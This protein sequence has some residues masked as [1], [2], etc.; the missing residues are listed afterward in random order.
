MDVWL[1]C[2]QNLVSTDSLAKKMPADFPITL[3]Y[4]KLSVELLFL[5]IFR[6]FY[7][8]LAFS[9]VTARDLMDYFWF[10]RN[11]FF[12]NANYVELMWCG[13][14]TLI[15]YF[16]VTE[17][18]NTLGSLCTMPRGM[19]LIGTW[20]LFCINIILDIKVAINKLPLLKGKKINWC[21]NK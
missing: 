20:V 13:R 16:I 11:V 5:L 2:K 6:L 1:Q 10:L 17:L 21:C 7:S 15:F 19:G 4:K 8:R 9:L 3:L 14:F 18:G 12:L